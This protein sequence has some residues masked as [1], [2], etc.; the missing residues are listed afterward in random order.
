MLICGSTYAIDVETGNLV[1]VRPHNY[2]PGGFFI[3]VKGTLKG[4]T[5][6]YYPNENFKVYFITKSNPLMK[7]LLSVAL[8]A[9][10]SD[11][12]VWVHGS[13][14]CNTNDGDGRGYEDVSFIQIN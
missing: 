13:G 9:Q 14:V 8:A 10:L 5:P 2:G 11:R 1:M 6:C 12:N 3:T 4:T 7:E